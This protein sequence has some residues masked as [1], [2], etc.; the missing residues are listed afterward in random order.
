ME[1]GNRNNNNGSNE[2]LGKLFKFGV[3]LVTEEYKRQS[4]RNRD[5]PTR[6]FK[7]HG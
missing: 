1:D 7:C 4:N 2:L 6:K 3:G 5:Q